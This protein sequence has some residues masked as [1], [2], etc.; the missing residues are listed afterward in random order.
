MPAASTVDLGALASDVAGRVVLPSD[1]DYDQLRAG[2]NGMIDR[3]PAGIVRI[4]SDGDA[5][6]AIAFAQEHELP[7]AI[8]LPSGDQRGL[9]SGPG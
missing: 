2:F 1:T 7:L 4:T 8:R 6:A 9:R 3:R 5:A